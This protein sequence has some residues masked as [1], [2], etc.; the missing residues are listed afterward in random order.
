VL[1]FFVVFG[2]FWYLGVKTQIVT[3]TIG[4]IIFPDFVWSS[5]CIA[6][7]LTQAQRSSTFEVLAICV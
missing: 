2:A 4:Q 5:I 7:S 3:R 1:E 6:D